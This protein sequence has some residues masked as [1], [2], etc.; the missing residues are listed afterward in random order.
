MLRSL[1]PSLSVSFRSLST[2][3]LVISALAEQ[4]AGKNKNK[5]VPYR[6]SVLTWLLKVHKG[7]KPTLFMPF[8]SAEQDRPFCSTGA[9]RSSYSTN[10][11]SKSPWLPEI[12]LLCFPS[13]SL[14]KVLPLWLFCWKGSGQL[15]VPRGSSPP[16]GVA[17][18]DQ[19]QLFDELIKH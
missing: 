3:G 7:Q 2:L 15:F 14:P 11:L 19:Q 16:P 17:T 6:D 12:Y 9:R 13:L 1:F 10:K 4:G 5:F 18:K 8:P